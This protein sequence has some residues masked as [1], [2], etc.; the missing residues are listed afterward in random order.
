MKYCKQTRNNGGSGE[1]QFPLISDLSLVDIR[2]QK[3]KFL[4]NMEL[5]QMILKIQ[6]LVWLLE[7]HLQLIEKEFLDIIL[8]MICLQV[9]KQM[10]FQDQFKHSNLQMKMEKFVL[11]NGSQDNQLW[12]QIML[13]LKRR[14]IGM[15]NIQNKLNDQQLNINMF[16]F[17]FQVPFFM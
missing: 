15:K 9:E 7:E 4:K 13:I 3:R 6:I 10:R 2:V 5:Q 8:L 1:I 16:Q 11:H 14:N 12:L 17:L